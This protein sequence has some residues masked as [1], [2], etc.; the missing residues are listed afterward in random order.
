MTPPTVRL[1]LIED[2]PEEL[3]L[4]RE[5]IAEIRHQHE[6][7]M[8]VPRCRV[9]WADTLERGLELIGRSG[10][11]V[12]LLD[13]GLE[14]TLAAE[15]VCA[16]RARA[17]EVPLIV[18]AN[19]ERLPEVTQLIRLGAQ[20]VL[21]KRD[22]DCLP[23]LRAISFAME[24]HRSES[25]IRSITYMDELTG[26][27]NGPGFFEVAHHSLAL[28]RRLGQRCDIVAVSPAAGG[29]GSDGEVDGDLAIIETADLLRAAAEPSHILARYSAGLFLAL[30]CGAGPGAGE[31]FVKRLDHACRVFNSHRAEHRQLAIASGMVSTDNA[32]GFEELLAAAKESLCENGARAGAAGCRR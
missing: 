2:D 16:L 20:D 21:V 24:R 31:L 7:R 14:G 18:L 22:L 13:S 5:M 29:G 11:D 32:P 26:L 27:Y 19:R 17:P 6:R 10:V 8:R 15:A 12:I 1:L 3:H 9:L 25:A 28:A 4:F 23:L 30:I